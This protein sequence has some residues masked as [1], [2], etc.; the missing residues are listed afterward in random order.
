MK[1]LGRFA[2]QVKVGAAAMTGALLMSAIASPA[3]ADTV[4]WRTIIGIIQAGNVVGNIGG[5]G[6]PWSTLG[7]RAKVDLATGR[8]DFEVD[9]L[10]LAGGNTIGNPGAINQVKGTVVCIVGA[11]TVAID[12]VLVPL[13]AQ[14]DAEFSGSVG[15][16]PSTCTASNVAFLVRIA[17]NRWIANG[18][19]R[20]SG[21]DQ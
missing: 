4:R 20:S 13:S 11:T 18:A 21:R 15:P 1:N 16:I 12:T 10:V 7:G 17:A 19:V 2:A 6:Q 3:A 5:G 9:G 14:G 8:V